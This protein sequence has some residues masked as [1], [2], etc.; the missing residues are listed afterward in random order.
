MI[1][2]DPP[3]SLWKPFPSAFALDLDIERPGDE[4]RLV[5][6]GMAV[7]RVLELKAATSWCQNFPAEGRN[8]DPGR[9]NLDPGRRN[10]DP[11]RL[12]G[13]RRFKNDRFQT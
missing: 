7:V 8:F 3:L 4:G 11:G 5:V 13:S 6:E 9:R 10:F 12:A 1:F 2:G